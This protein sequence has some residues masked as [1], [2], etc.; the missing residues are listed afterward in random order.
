[1]RFISSFSKLESITELEL[2]AGVPPGAPGVP[3]AG[4]GA[5]RRPGRQEAAP[6]TR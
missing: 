2:L 6:R 5:P 4:G 3:R 1:M